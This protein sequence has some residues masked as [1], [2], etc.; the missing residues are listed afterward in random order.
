MADRL[1]Y[2]EWINSGKKT[3]IDYA[4][5]KYGE[6]LK[7]HKPSPLTDEQDQKIECILEDIRKHYKVR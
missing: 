4:K 5:A 1:T 7:T 2:P 6:I 3:A